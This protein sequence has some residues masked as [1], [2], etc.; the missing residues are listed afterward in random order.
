MPEGR[1]VYQS[2]PRLPMSFWLPTKYAAIATEYGNLYD[3]D[4]NSLYKLDMESGRQD[5]P[6]LHRLDMP[7]SHPQFVG[8]SSGSL[9]P[10]HQIGRASLGKECQ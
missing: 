6:L 8:L 2:I 10:I 1:D 4:L 9:H 3:S 7:D 5:A